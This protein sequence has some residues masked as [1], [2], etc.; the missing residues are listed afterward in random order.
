[1]TTPPKAY[2]VD[3]E[4]MIRTLVQRA[5]EAR[6]LVVE[7]FDDAI[8][9]Y[10]RIVE[11]DRPDLIIS[12]VNMTEMSGT[13]L[14]SQLREMG[15][16]IPFVMMTGLPKDNDDALQKCGVE[17]IVVKPFM[18]AQLMA[19]ADEALQSRLAPPA[20]PKD[21]HLIAGVASWPHSEQDM[22]Q[23]E[24][25]I[26]EGEALSRAEEQEQAASAVID[27]QIDQQE[28][29]LALSEINGKIEQCHEKI[30]EAR[31]VLLEAG[32]LLVD[33]KE[34]IA[35]YTAIEHKP[36]AEPSHPVDPTATTGEGDPS[37]AE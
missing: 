32:G 4:P 1:M 37:R 19:A 9:A 14:F 26:A 25:T 30:E 15:L 18:S 17:Q 24:Q 10:R 8:H 7:S 35:A 29:T 3:D 33:L 2:V 12:D 34:L 11:G 16:N 13:T 27:A 28:R 22:S 31:M 23:L 6:G 21:E 5:L 20:P 36:E